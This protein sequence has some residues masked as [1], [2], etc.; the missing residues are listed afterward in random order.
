MNNLRIA[1]QIFSG[2]LTW[3]EAAK[4]ECFEEGLVDEYIE[5]LEWADA[6]NCDEDAE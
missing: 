3:E 1:K 5:E 4:Y 6:N 2:K